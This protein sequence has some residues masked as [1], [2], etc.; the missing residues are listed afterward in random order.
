MGVATPPWR[1]LLLSQPPSPLTPRPW[2]RGGLVT[3]VAMLLS[4]GLRYT[5]D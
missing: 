5:Y 2:H 4:A 3:R 1:P